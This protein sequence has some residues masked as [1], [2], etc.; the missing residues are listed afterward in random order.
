MKLKTENLFYLYKK[1]LDIE[2]L[3]EKVLN[4]KVHLFNFKGRKL[5]IV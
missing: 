4:F 5:K 2:D 3:N 1:F